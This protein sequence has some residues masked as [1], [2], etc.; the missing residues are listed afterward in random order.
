MELLVCP[1]VFGLCSAERN[2]ASWY[3]CEQEDAPFL[4]TKVMQTPSFLGGWQILLCDGPEGG[5]DSPI[6]VVLS[7][8]Y[9]RRGMP[10]ICQWSACLGVP[11]LSLLKLFQ[12]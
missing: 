7:M 11:R 1:T 9:V 10:A 12:G 4:S 3:L 6:S 2:C 8:T 5:G